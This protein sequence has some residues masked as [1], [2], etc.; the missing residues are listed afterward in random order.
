MPFFPLTKVNSVEGFCT[1]H[2]FPPND[3]Q[4]SNNKEKF[5]WAIYPEN[6]KWKTKKISKINHGESLTINYRDLN[7]CIEKKNPLILLQLRETTLPKTLNILP[8]HE[9]TY[10]DSPVWRATI[11]F[12]LGNTQT[13][14]QGE[15]NPFPQKAS[16]LT[17]HPFIQYEKTKNYFIFMNLESSPLNRKAFIEIYRSQS[18]EFVDKIEIENNCTNEIP[19]DIYDFN[20]KE[21]PV[22]I[23]RDMAGIPFGFGINISDKMISLEHT[24]P[25]ASF[26]LHGDRF[27]VQKRIKS[28]WL[29]TLNRPKSYD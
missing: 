5:I 19:L 27:L 21:L 11:G 13:S 29:E 10:T 22:F 18:K 28:E 14:Y 26:A 17:F 7:I 1:I 12:N 9:F 24:H 23:C 25:P 6:N 15:I 4:K 20:S 16:L 8:K 3:W 2:N